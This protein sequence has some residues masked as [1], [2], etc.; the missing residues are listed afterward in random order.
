LAWIIA[1]IL[2]VFYVLGLFV[3]HGTGAIHVL[4]FLALVVLATD[5][6]VTKRFRKR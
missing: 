1:L 6:L 2:L 4:P 3:F 5:Y